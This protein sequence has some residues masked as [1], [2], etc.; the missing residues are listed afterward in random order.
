[1]TK[2][3]YLNQKTKI[4][5][6]YKYRKL[7]VVKY[8]D[9]DLQRNVCYFFVE[10]YIIYKTELTKILLIPFHGYKSLKR[11]MFRS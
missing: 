6:L 1:M 9:K 3:N 10:K 7:L 2:K 4:N 8:S 11:F 5:K